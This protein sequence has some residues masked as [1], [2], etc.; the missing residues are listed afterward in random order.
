MPPLGLKSPVHP[1]GKALREGGQFRRRGGAGGEQE[2]LLPF[3]EL[4][5]SPGHQRLESRD[6]FSGF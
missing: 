2:P 6:T 1:S 3:T 4:L 5:S